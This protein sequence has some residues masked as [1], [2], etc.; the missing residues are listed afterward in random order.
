MYN[1]KNKLTLIISIQETT[2]EHTK[3]GVTQEWVY[4]NLIYPR[5]FISR[6]TYYEYLGY[7][8]KQELRKLQDNE[9][10]SKAA[11]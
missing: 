6:R 1:R 5:F 10:K 2:L 11:N 7:N 9:S 3:K 4:K 8:A